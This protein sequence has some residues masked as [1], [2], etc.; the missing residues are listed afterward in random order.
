MGK[1]GKDDE[2]MHMDIDQELALV[3]PALILNENVEG[4]SEAT[5]RAE[6]NILIKFDSV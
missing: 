2:A 6:Y 5:V 1:Y 3:L 4:M